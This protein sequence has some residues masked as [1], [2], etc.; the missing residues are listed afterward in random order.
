MLS[1]I[2]KQQREYNQKIFGIEGHED[3]HYWTQQYLL[4]ITS[5]VAEMLKAIKWKRHRN[6]DG[7][8]VIP[9]NVL[10]EVADVTKYAISIAQAW[11]YTEEDLL[12]AIHEKGDILDF[13]LKMEFREPL[14]GRQ[15]LI[16]DVD[17][18]IADYRTSFLKWLS[19]QGIAPTKDM[20]SILLDE[21]LEL[22]YPEYYKL[23]E[24]YEEAGG[25][26]DLEPYVDALVALDN[27]KQRNGYYIIAVTARP[28]H[29]YKRIFKDTLFWFRRYNL[30]ID[31]LHIMDD[32]RI[33]LASELG[34]E[35]DVILWEDNPSLLARASSSKIR[36]FAR[37]QPYNQKLNLP[38]V[39]HV[40]SYIE[41]LPL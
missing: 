6:E 40:E 37:I 41:Y 27:L 24:R 29:I 31:E 23:K 5:Q 22:E 14:R 4:G 21:S 16:T 3:P 7:K 19:G 10:E 2:W 13:R 18:T 39:H 26:R 34:K 25:Y 17:G 11:G 28:A 15:I 33:L 32:G 38:Y 1:R 12:E 20:T 30:P 8:K 36:T 9:L 35:N